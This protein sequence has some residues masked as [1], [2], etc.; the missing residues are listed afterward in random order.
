MS[1][2]PV[3]ETPYTEGEVTKCPTCGWD[4]T[5]LP[6]IVGEI[7][8]AFVAQEKAKL[9]WAQ[10]LWSQWE[11]ASQVSSEELEALRQQNRESTQSL[12]EQ[13]RRIEHLQ[14]DA[15]NY[16]QQLAQVKGLEK[17]NRKLSQ[18]L[19][20][21]EAKV[22][23]LQETSKQEAEQ[24]RTE[25]EKIRQQNRELTQSLQKKESQI[26]TLQQEKKTLQDNFNQVKKSGKNLKKELQKLYKHRDVIDAHID[27]VGTFV[28]SC[29]TPN[30]LR[31][32]AWS[33]LFLTFIFDSNLIS[34]ILSNPN[35]ENQ[36]LVNWENQSLVDLFFLYVFV[37]YS[38]LMTSTIDLNT[39]RDLNTDTDNVQQKKF[40]WLLKLIDVLL[41]LI[42][43]FSL[44]IL[45]FDTNLL[46][47]S[48]EQGVGVGLLYLFIS[49]YFIVEMDSVLSRPYF[50]IER[51]E[52]FIKNNDIKTKMVPHIR[53][54]QSKDLEQLRQQQESRQD[55]E[56]D[57]AVGINY[58]KL[59]ELLREKRWQEAD[60]ETE[61]IIAVVSNMLPAFKNTGAINSP[62][63]ISMNPD[64]GNLPC[65]DLRTID[66]LWVEASKGRFGFSVKKQI[67]QGLV[68]RDEP[69]SKVWKTFESRMQTGPNLSISEIIS[70][71]GYGAINR[72]PA[73]YF[74]RIFVKD[75]YEKLFRRMEDCNVK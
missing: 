53:S 31:R 58:N 63:P 71:I 66:Q 60:R 16:Q 67:F 51:M 49:C 61:A 41:K 12:Q 32:A 43:V 52:A 74:P 15:Q 68:E 3:C 44:L 17:E 5:S 48:N 50:Y 39:I 1:N 33:F 56:R 26:K 45:V 25:R 55:T 59:R 14:Q 57:S 23:K 21:K 7:P 27:K 36:S 19:Q 38:F 69:E 47:M 40:N 46:P 29:D 37:V 72:V 11:K 13:Q 54:L 20:E 35:W 65:R 62:Q 28:D 2:C 8:E 73:G 18:S 42:S 10:Q 6:M 9:E 34:T 64:Y 70:K 30:L 24:L 22:E 4:L 75:H